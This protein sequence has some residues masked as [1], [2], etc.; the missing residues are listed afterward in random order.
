MGF[1]ER[2]KLAENMENFVV[3]FLLNKNFILEKTGYES[4]TS[5]ETREILR[6]I[7]NDPTI[8]FMRYMP[9]YF[10]GFKDKF[11]FIEFKAMDSPIRLDSRVEELKKLTGLNHLSRQNIG[12]VETAAIKNY[13]NL[14]KLGV[15]ILVVVYSTFHPKKLLIEWESN[16]VKFYNDDVQLGQGNASFTPFTNIDLDKMQDFKGFFK[17]EFGLEISDEEITELINKIK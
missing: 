13:E 15:R 12:V 3:K 4:H 11:F 2:I 7:H 14:S 5:K 8:T 1:E 9:D 10:S 16:I 6:K 17:K